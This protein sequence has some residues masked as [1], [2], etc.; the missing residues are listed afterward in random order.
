MSGIVSGVVR[1]APAPALCHQAG[2]ILDLVYPS[3][4]LCSAELVVISG[5]LL[6]W[7]T[8]VSPR[9]GNVVGLVGSRV[10][11]T[12][13]HDC[14]RKDVGVNVTVLSPHYFR[15]GV[16]LVGSPS[17]LSRGGEVQSEVRDS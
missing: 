8:R 10:C 4:G 14:C 9:K 16:R 5:L 3:P 13:G 12:T 17:T 1:S 6:V 2:V 15:A 7:P 11:S